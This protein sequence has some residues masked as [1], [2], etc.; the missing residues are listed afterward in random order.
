MYDLD[1][2]VSGIN[3][4]PPTLESSI[5]SR[6]IKVTGPIGHRQSVSQSVCTKRRSDLE[7]S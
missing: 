2:G 1:K 5:G 4:N 3:M 6:A 7:S